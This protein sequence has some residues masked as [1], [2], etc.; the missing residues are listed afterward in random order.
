MG[1]Q[2]TLLPQRAI[3]WSHRSCLLIADLHLG[4]ASHFRKEGI[5]I[6]ESI[7]EEDYHKLYE[8][9]D[10]C[11]V[12]DVYFLGDLFHSEYNKEWTKLKRLIQD[13]PSTTFHLILGN[14]DILNRSYYQDA[15]LRV[16]DNSLDLE[17][18]RLVHE[19]PDSNKD[20]DKFIL[21]GHIHP[22]VGI[23]GKGR[24]YVRLACF[25]LSKKFMILPAYGTF[26]G[27]KTLS[28]SGGNIAYAILN[29]KVVPITEEHSK[30]K[31]LRD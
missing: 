8:L 19:P 20:E 18:F 4:K 3:Y 30:R 14:H 2:L 6:P 11:P 7:G 24:Q 15:G 27:V 22:G 25:Y 9:L 13:Y 28:L 12:K 23:G 31:K 10:S 1:E 5:A 26:T 29:D 21:C 16:Y 17:P